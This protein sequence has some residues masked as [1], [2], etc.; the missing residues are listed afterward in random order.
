MELTDLLLVMKDEEG[1]HSAHVDMFFDSEGVSLVADDGERL[2]GHQIHYALSVAF[3]HAGAELKGI[4][5]T[6]Q[7]AAFLGHRLYTAFHESYEGIRGIGEM[8]LAEFNKYMRE[9][10]L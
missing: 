2:T 3:V 8:S 1:E 10:S 6:P 5:L 7:D 4:I 9:H